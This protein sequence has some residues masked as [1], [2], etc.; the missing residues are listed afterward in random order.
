MDLRVEALERS[1]P[2]ID[3]V[4]DAGFE[5]YAKETIGQV[6][7]PFAFCV[8]DLK[9]IVG[10]CKGYSYTEDLYI[11]Q[12]W[13]HQN[14]RKV[15]LGRRIVDACGLL[16]CQRAC[17]RMWVDTYSY[18]SPGFYVHCGFQERDRIV[19]YRGSYDRIFFVKALG[20][21]LESS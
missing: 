10:A 14:F 2:E 13:V 8:R 20:S 9:E 18:Q 7:N 4:L 5:D 19:G 17:V 21:F 6:R 16:A 1:T 12:L 15:G 3:S 11:S